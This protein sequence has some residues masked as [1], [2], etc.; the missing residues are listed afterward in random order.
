MVKT[1]GAAAAPARPESARAAPLQLSGNPGCGSC[2]P[3][4]VT[5]NE[6]RDL[7][8][9][10]LD[11]RVNGELLQS[12][13]CSDLCFSDLCFKVPQIVACCSGFCQLNP[14]DI[15]ATGKPSGRSLCAQ[16]TTLAESRR[17]C[18]SGDRRYWCAG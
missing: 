14:G 8:Q 15:I 10:G 2:G 9:R 1:I 12:T 6:L 11:I 4:L 18:G 17:P 5:A 16:A 7:S 13:I 3:W